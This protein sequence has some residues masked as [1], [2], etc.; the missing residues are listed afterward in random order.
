MPS[1]ENKGTIEHP[2]V[3]DRHKGVIIGKQPKDRWWVYLGCLGAEGAPV[4]WRPVCLA[5]RWVIETTRLPQR[6]SA[7]S[8]AMNKDM[9]SLGRRH[10]RG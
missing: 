9:G 10:A 5:P 1:G 7:C 2:V 6:C 8:R 4:E 3:G